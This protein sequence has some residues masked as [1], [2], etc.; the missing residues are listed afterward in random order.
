MGVSA[1]LYQKLLVGE[2]PY[3]VRVGTHGA[4][5]EHRHPDLELSYC[6]E[7]EY[8][9]R[10]GD[11]TYRM[12][13]GDFAVV[14]SMVVHAY[15]A[16]R[17][18]NLGLN[19]EVGPA[20]LG[21]FFEAFARIGSR[22]PIL[23]PIPGDALHALLEETAALSSGE[24][25]FSELQIKGNLYKICSHILKNFPSD[26]RSSRDLR[27]VAS[28]ER[29]LATIRTRYAEPLRLCD[30][31]AE[32]GYRESNFCK[33][34]KGITGETFHASLNRRRV[35]VACMLLS[36]SNDAVESIAQQVGFPDAKSFCR[37]FKGATGL[38]PNTY[39]KQ[40]NG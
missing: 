21:E 14:G 34:F 13:K 38:T 1:L 6:M 28:I 29:A 27:G 3:C 15:D 8:T 5:C 20:F 24:E 31:A 11:E 7:G 40:M 37:V 2:R 17:E 33:V 39:R 19:I 35:E 32:N 16:N 10:I 9:L 12:K 25:A 22:A 30:V 23:R 18:E 4:F 36:D 26:E